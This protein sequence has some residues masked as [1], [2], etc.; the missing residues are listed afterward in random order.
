VQQSYIPNDDAVSDLA[1]GQQGVV[2]SGSHR[3]PG[4]QA[5]WIA[6]AADHYTT[7]KLSEADIAGVKPIRN[8]D[9]APV[10]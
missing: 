1:L 9:Q 4:S 5:G 8:E 3:H 2:Y 10:I 6:G 7:A